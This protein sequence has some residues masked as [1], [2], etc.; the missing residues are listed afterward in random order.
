MIEKAYGRGKAILMGTFAG[1]AYQGKHDRSTREL[2]LS[3]AQAAGVTPEVLVSGPGTSEVE[4]RRLASADQQ[5]V[6][7][8]N[9]ASGAAEARISLRVP[10]KVR[11]ARDLVGDQDVPVQASGDET[12]LQ[13]NLAPDAI[14]VVRLERQ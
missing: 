3:L 4:V 12:V 14:W 1:L 9:P 6:F 8:F 13:K 11:R 5:F 7:V 2:L 10:W